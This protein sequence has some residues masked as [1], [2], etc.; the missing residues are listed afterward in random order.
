MYKKVIFAAVVVISGGVLLFQTKNT[1]QSTQITRAADTITAI[2]TDISQPNAKPQSNDKPHFIVQPFPKNAPS[3]EY[4]FSVGNRVSSDEQSQIQHYK[5]QAFDAFLNGASKEFAADELLDKLRWNEVNNFYHDIAIWEALL[6]H[7]ELLA[8]MPHSDQLIANIDRF[9]HNIAKS[10]GR[11]VDFFMQWENKIMPLWQDFSFEAINE[12]HNMGAS[13]EELVALI[14]TTFSPVPKPI[15]DNAYLSPLSGVIKSLLVLERITAATLLF[16]Q[17]PELV[18]FDN[19]YEA[20]PQRM[21]LEIIGEAGY[22]IDDLNTLPRLI[23]SFNFNKHPFALNKEHELFSGLINTTNALSLLSRQGI[24]IDVVDSKTL[25]SLAKSSLISDDPKYVSDDALLN[26]HALC[27]SKNVWVHQRRKAKQQWDEFASSA[28]ID[29][30]KK[31]PEY[32]YCDSVPAK[33]D[34]SAAVKFTAPLFKQAREQL[35]TQQLAFRQ[36]DLTQINVSHLKS[37]V[38]TL[39]SLLMTREFISN[40]HLTQSDIIQK[41][42]DANLIP[43]P[44]DIAVLLTFVKRK[45]LTMWLPLMDFS[46]VPQARVLL[47]AM[48]EEAAFKQF[49]ILNN[50]LQRTAQA[51]SEA[52]D[53]FYFFIRGFSELDFSF[54]SANED[55]KNVEDR[56]HQRFITYF[57]E[58]PVAIREFHRRAVMQHKSQ[59]EEQYQ[60]IIKHFPELEIDTVDDFFNVRCP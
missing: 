57:T 2:T 9:S 36:I 47:N 17:Y 7:K 46:D 58:H 22:M 26:E 59:L 10:Q 32:R 51:S 44:K 33:L 53:P 14:N 19:K 4:C 34:L 16:E 49:E 24:E 37:D 23:K 56:E 15:L 29:V 1:A 50:K 39:F 45:N 42:T 13:D 8:S 43:N 55:I 3:A 18:S 20:Q 11:Y 40:S 60:A 5:T 30:V 6:Q 54:F 48:A 27:N 28:F 52:L 38:K 41:L 31:S 25:V 35:S 12:A 21:T